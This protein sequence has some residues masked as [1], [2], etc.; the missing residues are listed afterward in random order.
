MAIAEA[1]EALTEEEVCKYAEPCSWKLQGGVP[2][3]GFSLGLMHSM[4]VDAFCLP[5]ADLHIGKL[6]IFMQHT[7]LSWK[8]P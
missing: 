3:L 2:A 5:L 7:P 4:N 8:T 1:E 6:T